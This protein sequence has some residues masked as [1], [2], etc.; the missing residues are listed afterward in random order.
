MLWLSFIFLFPCRELV[1]KGHK[2][3]SF[4]CE[5]PKSMS[6]NPKLRDH[7]GNDFRMEVKLR[8][9]NK[10]INVQGRRQDP[11]VKQDKSSS[12]L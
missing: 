1:H 2:T 7:K 10:L 3:N 12:L 8:Y 4:V 6:G 9:P 11:V 5:L